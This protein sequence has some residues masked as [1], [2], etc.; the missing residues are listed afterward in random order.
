V[1]PANES[2][3]QHRVASAAEAALARKRYVSAIDVL[4]G[5]GLLNWPRRTASWSNRCHGGFG[6]S[7]PVALRPKPMQLPGTPLSGEA[8]ASGGR[9]PDAL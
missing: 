1:N 4:T 7:S 3:L 9:P 6:K 2:A 8:A 5:M